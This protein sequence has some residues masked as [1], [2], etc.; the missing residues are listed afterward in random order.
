MF[1]RS[2]AGRRSRARTVDALW[3]CL[4][5]MPQLVGLLLFG[6]APLV[7]AFGLSF[8]AWSG[9]GGTTFVGLANFTA[10]WHSPQFWTA[11]R[12]T[13]YYTLLVVPGNLTLSL[14]I[15]LGI[16]SVRGQ[17]VY[18]VAYFLPVVTSAVVVSVIWLSLLNADYGLIN[19]YLRAWFGVEGPR[20]LTDRRLV[21]PSIALLSIWWGL[22][23]NM[24][25]FLA[26]LQG[27]PPSYLEAARLDGARSWQLFRY[28][29]LPLLT[30][31]MFFATIITIISSFQVFDQ[32][33]VLTRGGPGYA[34]YTLVYHIYTLAFVRFDFGQSSAVALLL[35][36]LLLALTLLQFR[37]QRRWVFYEDEM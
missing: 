7:W 13:A 23:F 16:N 25:I 18:R 33:Y 12:N 14:L 34:S 36:G 26:G 4:F 30:P 3:G 8:T 19:G 17:G 35:F 24:V 9:L 29:T 31:T 1:H 20:W 21:I 5:V 11:L 15:A 37:A 10:Q 6:V 28:V 32:A 27:I 22:G 2:L